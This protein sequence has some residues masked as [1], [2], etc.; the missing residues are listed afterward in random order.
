MFSI[1]LH[2]RFDFLVLHFN[3]CYQFIYLAFIVV[4][5]AAIAH[6]T[7]IVERICGSVLHSSR[8]ATYGGSQH[9]G[10][11]WW[12]CDSDSLR[13]GDFFVAGRNRVRLRAGR[14]W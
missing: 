11:L 6:N 12:F 4:N 13:S 7:A 10:S 1:K 3:V 8:F 5:S 14:D 2:A 9:H